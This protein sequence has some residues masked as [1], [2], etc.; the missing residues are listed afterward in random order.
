MNGLMRSA[1][2]LRILRTAIAFSALIAL[3]AASACAGNQPASE[4]ET[5]TR[6]LDLVPSS[7]TAL[8]SVQVKDLL[9]DPDLDR[10]RNS[11]SDTDG[12]DTIPS[13]MS[14]ALAEAE[15]ATGLNIE[16]IEEALLFFTE[17]PL[18]SDD[19]E[20]GDDE[21]GN[22]RGAVLLRVPYD[23]T[24][25]IAALE[26][27][28]GPL[29]A[30]Q[31][32]GQELLTSGEETVVAFISESVI[33]VGDTTGVQAVV[34]VSAGTTAAVA[35]D[36]RS[37]FEALGSPWVKV[38]IQ[39]AREDL[40]STLQSEGGD[41]FGEA[42]PFMDAFAKLTLIKVT[43]E[44]AGGAFV[45]QAM[46]DFD[47]AAAAQ[48]ASDGIDGLVKTFGAFSPDE[49]LG[50]LLDKITIGTVANQVTIGVQLTPA[51][52]EQAM[53]TMQAMDSSEGDSDLFF[54]E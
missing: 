35:G 30:S 26:K 14:D 24:S 37:A 50:Q 10:L 36:L 4:Q 19:T 5:E 45:F 16:A 18:G 12:E 9:A 22:T 42:P 13:S 11:A 21:D 31:Y 15:A 41:F 54:G 47:D 25:V 39:P 8:I 17:L 34:D 20:S 29:V 2:V 1:L 53:Q 52:V 28:E 46:L 48:Q 32:N 44:K 6:L 40:E 23:R 51:E 49:S 3:I 27:E 43:F 33:V 7:A 38:V